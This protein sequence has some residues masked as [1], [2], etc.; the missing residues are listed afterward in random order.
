MLSLVATKSCISAWLNKVT[1]DP[2]TEKVQS[3]K[4]E[5]IKDKTFFLP[6]KTAIAS[7]FGCSL[8]NV[9]IKNKKKSESQITQNKDI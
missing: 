6:N 3:D 5:V 4:W 8:K 1:E 7:N 2:P 9:I